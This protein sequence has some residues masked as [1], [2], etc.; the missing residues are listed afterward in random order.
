MPSRWDLIGRLLILLML[1]LA[2]PEPA[3]ADSFV[4][5]DLFIADLNAFAKNGQTID[6]TSDHTGTVTAIV[7]PRMAC[8]TP[9]A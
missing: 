9:S 4:P 5:G 8:A 2:V 3:S 1:L 7:I 6:V